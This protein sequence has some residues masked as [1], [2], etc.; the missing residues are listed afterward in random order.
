MK[1][2]IL[3]FSAAYVITMLAVVAIESLFDLPSGTSMTC[4][5]VGGFSAAASFVK[6][7]QRVPYATEK[8]TLVWGCLIA[9]IIVSI[10]ATLISIVVFPETLAFLKMAMA[11]LPV[12]IWLIAIAF[13]L[14][15]HYLILALSFGWMAKRFLPKTT[16]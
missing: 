10:I 13:T 1:K 7:R 16:V 11:Q 14:L 15:I 2:Y 4:L 5:I 8:K 9:S 3:T 6:D 12:W